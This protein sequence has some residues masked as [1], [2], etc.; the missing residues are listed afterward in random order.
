MTDELMISICFNTRLR[1]DIPHYSYIFR[2]KQCGVLKVRK[3]VI[4][5]DTKLGG[6][7][8]DIGI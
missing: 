6:G 3:Y 2:V 4:P 1:G 8:T 5:R 7:N